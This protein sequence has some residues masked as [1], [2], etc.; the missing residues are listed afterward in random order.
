MSA[1]YPAVG[2]SRRLALKKRW[3]RQLL[4]ILGVHLELCGAAP[5]R[6][7][8]IVANHVSWLDVFAINAVAPAAFVC[9]DEVRAWPLIGWLCARTDTIFITRGN[10]GAARRTAETLRA[11]LDSGEWAVVFPEG[12]TSEGHGVLNFFPALLQ[13]ALDV[14]APVQ[15]FA[16]RYTDAS[17]T[18]RLEPAYVG[19]TSFWECLRAIV[20]ARGLVAQVHPLGETEADA[21]HRRELALLA[22]TRIATRLGA[23]SPSAPEAPD[24]APP[25]PDAQ[26]TQPELATSSA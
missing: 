6:P 17:G 15:P 3:S 22:Q 10:R 4:S 18:L 7:G 13:P 21:S 2:Q 14:G 19:E 26:E 5:V 11:V 16:L 9:K 25:S 12:T 1:A 24:P 23:A 20:R 8:L